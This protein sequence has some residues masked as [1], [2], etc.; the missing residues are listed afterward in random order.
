MKYLDEW[1]CD[2]CNELIGGEKS[3][4]G[5]WFETLIG[6]VGGVSR[7]KLDK[8]VCS[9]ER[10]AGDAHVKFYIMWVVFKVVELDELF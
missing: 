8:E 7:K 3:R 5:C 6:N 10:F 1:V 4:E 2:P 9:R